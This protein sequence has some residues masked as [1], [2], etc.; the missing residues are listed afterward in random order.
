V[1]SKSIQKKLKGGRVDNGLTGCEEVKWGEAKRKK[2]WTKEKP[3]Y[4]QRSTICACACV[5]V[6]E[7]CEKKERQKERKSERER[8]RKKESQ[9]ILVNENDEKRE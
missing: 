9:V 1:I 6:C 7:W 5:S 8:E 4:Q 2:E 3:P